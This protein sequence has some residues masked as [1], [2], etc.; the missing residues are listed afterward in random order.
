MQHAKLSAIFLFAIVLTACNSG[1][2]AAIAV[3]PAFINAVSSPQCSGK[4]PGTQYAAVCVDGAQV[5]GSAATLCDDHQGM[6]QLFVCPTPVAEDQT[7]VVQSTQP[8]PAQSPTD[9]PAETVP[10]SPASPS[11]EIEVLSSRSYVGGDYFHIVGEVRNNTDIPME[12]VKIVATLYDDGGS[13]T[14]TDFTYT[15]LDIIPPHG[16][17]PFETGTDEWRGTTK[18]KLQTESRSGSLGRQDLQ[19]LSHSGYRDGGYYLIKGEVKNAGTYTANSVKLVVTFYDQQGSVLMGDFGY[20]QLDKIPPGETSPFETG[21]EM[22]E[23]PASYE[24][25]VQGR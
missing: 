10:P 9:M 14:G 1:K 16:K 3:T 20:T 5:T 6:Y 22:A 19:I 13:V 15:E 21:V 17:S 23:D 2:P 11:T 12:S 7:A 25:Q 4:L 24:I 18:Y 8:A